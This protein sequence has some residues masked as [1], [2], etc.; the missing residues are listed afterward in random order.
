MLKPA[1]EVVVH[2]K[3]LSTETK[4]LERYHSHVDIA[5]PGKKKINS[6]IFP[7]K[8]KKNLNWVSLIDYCIGE[9]VGVNVVNI[10]I[11]DVF[12]GIGYIVAKKFASTVNCT[13]AF[14]A[15]I[16]VMKPDRFIPHHNYTV[17]YG[18]SRIPCFVLWIFPEQGKNPDELFA[19]RKFKIE[20]KKP[21]ITKPVRKGLRKKEFETKM[22]EFEKD[23]KRFASKAAKREHAEFQKKKAAEEFQRPPRKLFKNATAILMPMV[24]YDIEKYKVT[25]FEKNYSGKIMIMQKQA[26][27]GVGRVDCV[28]QNS[29]QTFQIQPTNAGQFK[30]GT[31]V[32]KLTEL[33][34]LC[35]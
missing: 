6:V 21:E 20:R 31:Y 25:E 30:P 2:P 14:R 4:N 28:I 10:S 26:I 17:F 13:I 27:V 7:K 1:L 12:P 5:S 18:S 9:M 15:R 3:G 24:H 35:E 23:I 29:L 11:R 32:N 16:A 34:V 33:T 8:E 19:T 22:A